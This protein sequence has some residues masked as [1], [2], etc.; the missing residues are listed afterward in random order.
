MRRVIHMASFCTF[1]A[2][3]SGLAACGKKDE[4]AGG[5]A[6]GSAKAEEGAPDPDTG[7]KPGSCDYRSDTGVCTY[8]KESSADMCKSLGGKPIDGPCPTEGVLGTCVS[9]DSLTGEVK[10]YYPTSAAQYTAATA[11]AACEAQQGVWASAGGATESAAG[12]SAAANVGACTVKADKSCSETKLNNPDDS[13]TYGKM[14]ADINKGTWA[15]G[16]C[17]MENVIGEC[18]SAS[19]GRTVYYKGAKDAKHTCEQLVM[20]GRYTAASK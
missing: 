4:P 2:V 11:K 12:A 13:A 18:N 5:T 9:P 16:P 14:C 15:E 3:A 17:P 6:P 7:M 10:S 19:A 8:N 1:F 20:G